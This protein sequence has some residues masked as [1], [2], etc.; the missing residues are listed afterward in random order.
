MGL[1]YEFNAARRI[2][3]SFDPRDSLALDKLCLQI[4]EA[5]QELILASRPFLNR[6]IQ[7]C[8][9]LCCRN[10]Y[11]DEIIGME[12]FLYIL[13]LMPCLEAEIEKRLK[14]VSCLFTADCVFLENGRG[15][16]I[17]PSAIRPEVCI[18]S[19]C[20]ETPTASRQIGAVK[21]GFQKL[22]WFVRMRRA[23]ALFRGMVSSR[24][25]M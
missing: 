8:H 15:P 16:C 14:H 5:E 12:D 20:M 11:L 7:G 3:Q 23:R 22:A 18:T 1:V 2:K 24:F 17:F 19:F 13:C 6:C 10:A 25:K 4:Q 9:G 21:W